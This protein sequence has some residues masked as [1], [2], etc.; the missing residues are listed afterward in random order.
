M[1]MGPIVL[2]P[3]PP[4]SEP[5]LLPAK[6]VTVHRGTVPIFAA[7]EA[8]LPDNPPFRRENGTVP[9]ACSGEN[10]ERRPVNGYRTPNP[11]HKRKR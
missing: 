5:W 9:F 6:T 1:M 11:P 7:Q 8:S 4:P 2:P 3:V 10:C